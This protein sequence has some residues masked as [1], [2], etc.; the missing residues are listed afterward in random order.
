MNLDTKIKKNIEN[1]QMLIKE[2]KFNEAILVLKD[3]LKISKNNFETY[4]LLGT[5]NGLKNDMSLAELYLEEA[6]QINPQHINTI[7]NLAII[8]K[9]LGKIDQSIEYFKRLQELDCKNVNCLCGLAQ[10]YDEKRDYIKAEEYFKNAINIDQSHHVANHGYGK[11]LLK[12]NKHYHGLKL[13]EKA[14]GMIKFKK[15]VIEII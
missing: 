1:A 12:L 6:I 4:F 14:S 13:L 5:I 11:L 9:K 7:L 2:K 15:N 3:N 10:I 8:S